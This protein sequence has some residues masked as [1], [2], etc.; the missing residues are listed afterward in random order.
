[1]NVLLEGTP[2]HINLKTVEQTFEGIG[3]VVDV[4]DLHVWTITSGMEALSVHVV[5][6]GREPHDKLLGRI[7]DRIFEEHGIGHITVQLETEAE[8][9]SDE[10]TC[11]AGVNCFEPS[12]VARDSARGLPLE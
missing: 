7:R 4:H 1:M 5:H 9:T 8:S 6:D 11:F 3:N 12:T 2:S 10:H